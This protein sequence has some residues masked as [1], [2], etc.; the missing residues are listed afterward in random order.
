MS[1]LQT[2][3]TFPFEIDVSYKLL[4]TGDPGEKPLIIYLHG[5]KQN[6]NSFKKKA[7]PLL[8]L[9]ARHLFLQGPY[10]TF[11]EKKNSKMADWGRA[12]YLYDGNQEQFKNSL[13]KTSV[14][15]QK[16]IEQVSMKM[17]PAE[18]VLL[19]YSM[20]GYQAGYFA[21][22]RPNYVDDL[23]VIGGRI[24]T[25]FF[26]NHHYPNLTTLVLHGRKDR[27]V[28]IRQAQESAERLREM[29]ADVNFYGLEEGHRLTEPYIIKTREWLKAEVGEPKGR[30]Q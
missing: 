21:L 17:T 30:N 2:Q 28:N 9:D 24:K 25:E 19:G 8:K 20:G 14:F 16:V 15:I 7:T 10:I 23:V 6:L 26:S 29:G 3:H 13:E 22:S 1:Q 12:W 5:Y 18:T 11:N 4:E 27:S